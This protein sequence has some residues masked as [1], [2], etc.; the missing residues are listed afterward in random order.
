MGPRRLRKQQAFE[1]HHEEGQDFIVGP[2]AA[3]GGVGGM[4]R[5]PPR[6]SEI[7]QDPAWP[8]PGESSEVRLAK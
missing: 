5:A 4:S 2:R 1:L 8:Q 3:Q 7:S 6:E